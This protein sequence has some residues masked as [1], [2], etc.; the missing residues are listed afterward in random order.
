MVPKKP[1]SCIK[2]YDFEF[3]LYP[4]HPVLESF[5]QVLP[6]LYIDSG[7]SVFYLEFSQTRRLN[8]G[9]IASHQNELK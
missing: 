3:A 9:I 1:V 8:A 5:V 6:T 7:K 4:K 2:A